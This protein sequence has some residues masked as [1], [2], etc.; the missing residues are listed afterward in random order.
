MSNTDFETL[1]GK[2]S[3][4]TGDLNF[5][6]G[7]HIDGTIK[8]NVNAE[9]GS[10][11]VVTISE[12][13]KV[14]GEIRAPRVVIDGALNGDVHATDRVELASKARVQGNIY[15][16]SVQMALGARVNGSMSYEEA[17]GGQSGKGDRHVRAVNTEAS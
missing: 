11:A 14:E 10:D 9:T 16:K 15:Y 12:N 6:G 17:A 7:L 5:Q 2:N 13:G 3:V 8:G 4:L 1:I